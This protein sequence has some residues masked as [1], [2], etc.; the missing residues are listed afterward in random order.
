MSFADDRTLN[1]YAYSDHKHVSLFNRVFDFVW[2][3]PL[4]I[5]LQHSVQFSIIWNV[6][7]ASD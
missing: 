4:Y 7:Y 6:T 3:L 5:L 1:G 2:L